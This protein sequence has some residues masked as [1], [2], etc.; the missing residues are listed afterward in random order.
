MGL[1]NLASGASMWRGYEYY[2]GKKVV[3]CQKNGDAEIKG[4]VSG[5]GETRYEV[6]LNIEHPRNSH[7][8]CPHADGRRVVCKHMVA[9]YFSAFPAEAKAYYQ[10]VLDDEKRMEQQEEEWRKAVISH[11]SHM[12]KDELKKALLDILFYGPDWQY[13]QFIRDYVDR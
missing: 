1:L 3:S 11:V 6:F 9:L 13:D 2:K 8:N 12:R 4:I 7:C 10:R 5:S